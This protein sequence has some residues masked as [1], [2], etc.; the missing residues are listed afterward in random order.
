MGIS[1]TI[2]VI[3]IAFTI[4]FI[5]DKIKPKMYHYKNSIVTVYKK[6]QCPKRCAVNHHHYVHFDSSV[7]HND[8]MVINKSMLGKEY[9]IPPKK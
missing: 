5:N 9:K 3:G 4:G 8:G 2:I 1:E 6:Y 7:V